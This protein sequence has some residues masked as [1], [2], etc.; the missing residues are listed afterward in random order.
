MRRITVGYTA[1]H[2]PAGHTH[3][4]YPAI[5]FGRREAGLDRARVHEQTLAGLGERERLRDARAIHELRADDALERGELLADGRLRIAEA[6]RGAMERRL[7][8]EGLERSQ[9]ANLDPVPSAPPNAFGHVRSLSRACP[10]PR[11]YLARY[12]SDSEKKL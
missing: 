2:L 7:L 9:M 5:R 3:C 6:A 8:R 4:P 10:E 12:R 1:P 11:E